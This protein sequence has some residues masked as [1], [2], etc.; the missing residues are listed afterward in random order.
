[1][2]FSAAA[3]RVTDAGTGLSVHV[4]LEGAYP[5]RLAVGPRGVEDWVSLD[6]EPEGS[7]VRYAIELGAG[8]AGLRRVG[9]TL[10]LLDAGG[11]PRL[12]MAP[13]FVIGAD[14]ARIDAEVALEGCDA[15]T[16]PRAPWRRPITPPG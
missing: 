13:P 6:R 14:G 5:V 8:V 15:D 11:A 16:S 9:R 3:F 10:E 7:A 2:V 12:R 4:R 1:E